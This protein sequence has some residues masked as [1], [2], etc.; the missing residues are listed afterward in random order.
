MLLRVVIAVI[1]ITLVE[2][3]FVK[4]F[5]RA[6]K[7]WFEKTD[8]KTIN[9]IFR[10]AL[11]YLNLYPAII[12]VLYLY[13][14]ASGTGFQ[15][16]ESKVVDYL[17]IYPFWF[18]ILLIAQ[19]ILYL[20]VL[21]LLKLLILPIY[22]KHKEKRTVKKIDAVIVVVLITFFIFYVPI[23]VIY[24]YN[25]VSV[26]EVVY[27]KE[28]LQNDLKDFRIAFISDIQADRYTDNSRLKNFINKVNSA[29]PDLVLI[30]GDMITSTPNYIDTAAA[31]I[32]KINSEYGIYSCVGDHDNWAYRGDFVKSKFEIT[33][34]LNQKNI[35]M[36]DNNNRTL[37]IGD[38]EI[39]IT[40]ITNTYV[41]TVPLSIMQNLSLGGKYDLNI[42]LTHQPRDRFIEF[43]SKNDYDLLLAGH[44]HGGQVTFLFPFIHLSPTLFETTYLRGS[45]WF[46]DMLMIVTRGLGMSIV[47]LRYNS[48]PEVTLIKLKSK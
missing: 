32:G 34:A 19:T 41:E 46:D 47:P 5:A 13:G 1:L 40:F 33:K 31:F 48:T 26:R 17:I 39:G 23:R 45:F 20:L 16:P 44:T 28:N 42:F 43:A 10:Y 4:R 11:I 29:D 24:D 3:Y 9:K 36:I 22:K 30:A 27:E 38:A 21:D 25:N 8:P 35:F 37:Q 7:F 6:I 12:L 18:F 2:Y 14:V 15:L